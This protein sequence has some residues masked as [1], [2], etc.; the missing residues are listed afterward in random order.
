M[1][2]SS[3]LPGLW[4]TRVRLRHLRVDDEAFLAALDSDPAV[5]QYI[6][7]GPLSPELSRSWARLQVATATMERSWPRRWGKWVVQKRRS[8]VLLGWVEV[9]KFSVRSGDYPCLGYEFAPAFWGC[10]Y[11]TEAVSA[12]LGYLVRQ[13]REKYVFAYARPENLASIRVLTK[14]GFTKIKRTVLDEGRNRCS[15]YRLRSS[16][17]QRPKRKHD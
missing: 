3:K 13:L 12:V 9:G 7:V 6:N 11:A 17:F 4:A 5:M 10:G 15:L 2:R 14:T 8:N 1:R 16:Q